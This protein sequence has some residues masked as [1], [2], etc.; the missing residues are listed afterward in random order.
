MALFAYL[1]LYRPFE[2]VQILSVV[3]L[4]YM[5]PFQNIFAVIYQLLLFALLLDPEHQLFVERI[6]AFNCLEICLIDCLELLHANKNPQSFSSKLNVGQN[7]QEVNHAD[8]ES[9]IR[10]V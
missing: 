10:A 9:S 2:D 4:H 3:K 6:V 7:H 5:V 8:P 1:F